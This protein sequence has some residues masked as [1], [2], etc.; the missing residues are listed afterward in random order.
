MATAAIFSSFGNISEL[1]LWCWH[2]TLAS[3]QHHSCADR[4]KRL[5]SQDIRAL[6]NATIDRIAM[7]DRTKGCFDYPDIIQEKL[8]CLKFFNFSDDRSWKKESNERVE[9]ALSSNLW[10]RESI[11]I[12]ANIHKMPAY[13]RQELVKT[14]VDKISVKDRT[15]CKAEV[16]RKWLA[17]K[18]AGKKTR[19]R[20][21]GNLCWT[22]VSHIRLS[23]LFHIV[24]SKYKALLQRACFGAV[25]IV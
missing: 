3:S 10:S 21:F 16:R 7:L 11:V 17:S 4:M 8:N 12:C 22:M 24:V 5:V 13:L 1:Y 25:K 6:A 9:H 14:H 18:H 2:S 19:S 23:R 15:G 20:H